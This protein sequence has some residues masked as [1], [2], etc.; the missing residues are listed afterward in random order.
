[1]ERTFGVGGR[2]RFQKG[3]TGDEHWSVGSPLLIPVGHRV[4]GL[5]KVPKGATLR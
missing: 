5:E 1:M 4:N 3:G 2:K